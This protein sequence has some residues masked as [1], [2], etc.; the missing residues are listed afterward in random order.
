[1][2]FLMVVL[3]SKDGIKIELFPTDFI[4]KT[5]NFKKIHK[6]WLCARETPPPPFVQQLVWGDPLHMSF[7][8]YNRVEIEVVKLHRR[9]GAR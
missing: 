6:I 7:P 8:F 1:M 2:L 9:P 3:I 5:K 4:K